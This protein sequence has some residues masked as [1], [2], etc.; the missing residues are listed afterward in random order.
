MAEWL[1]AHAWP[2]AVVRLPSLCGTPALG[3]FAD[4]PPER[5]AYRVLQSPQL[6][7]SFYGII[8]IHT[9][10]CSSTE[11]TELLREALA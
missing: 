2:P 11:S 1:K 3:V 7:F 8:G 5:V 10:L 4:R 9:Y 6:R